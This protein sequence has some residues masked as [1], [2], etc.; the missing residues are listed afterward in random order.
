MYKVI[1]K[2]LTPNV[3]INPEKCTPK[4]AEYLCEFVNGVFRTD[5][6]DV[7]DKLQGMGHTVIEEAD[8]GEN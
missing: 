7:A 6:K 2:P 5:D 8:G 3:I 1:K 4:W